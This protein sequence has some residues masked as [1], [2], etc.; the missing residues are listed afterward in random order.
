MLALSMAASAAWA[1]SINGS[2]QLLCSALNVSVC[3]ADGSCETAPASSLQIPQFLLVDLEHKRLSTT[4]ASGDNR[5]T[6]IMQLVRENGQIRLQGAQRGRL[7][8]MVLQEATGEA[9]IAVARDGMIIGV[10]GAC[11]PSPVR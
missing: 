2:S 9:T 4:Q 3:A 1:D 5:T 7:F 10:F 8:S 6:P 11:T